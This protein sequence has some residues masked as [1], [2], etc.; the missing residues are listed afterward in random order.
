[1]SRRRWPWLPLVPTLGG[2]IATLALVSAPSVAHAYL[3]LSKGTKTSAAGT[4]V[5]ILREG[6]HDVVSLRFRIKDKGDKVLV[7]VPVPAS[8]MERQATAGAPFAAM[9][10]VVSPR[11]EELWEQD[12]CELHG[13]E[14]PPLGPSG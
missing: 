10:S 4:S 6:E 1:M 11:V 14:P 9:A 7:V 13:M 8:V 12:P 2:T 5:V 3:L